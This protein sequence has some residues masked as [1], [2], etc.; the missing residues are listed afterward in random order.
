MSY[1]IIIEDTQADDTV[2]IT[3]S[4]NDR[5]DIVNL[6]KKAMEVLGFVFPTEEE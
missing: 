3:T 1:R 5:D 6:F 4:A 2:T